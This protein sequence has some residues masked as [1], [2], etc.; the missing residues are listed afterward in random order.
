LYA[1]INPEG[2]TTN[3]LK[4]L[5][6]TISNKNTV[7]FQ[8]LDTQK[9]WLTLAE[10]ISGA[11]SWIKDRFNIKINQSDENKIFDLSIEIDKQYALNDT[12]AF[13]TWDYEKEKF[14]VLE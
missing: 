2:V 12:I 9:F 14:V 5:L 1:K 13:V 8:S 7:T 10:P 6:E 3:D 11:G 4:Q